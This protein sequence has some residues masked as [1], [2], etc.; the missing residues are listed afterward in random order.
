MK[1]IAKLPQVQHTCTHD[2]IMQ[3]AEDHRLDLIHTLKNMSAS[4]TFRLYV[5]WLHMRDADHFVV[6]NESVNAHKRRRDDL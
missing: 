3:L 5:S 6:L 4:E 2:S 1:D